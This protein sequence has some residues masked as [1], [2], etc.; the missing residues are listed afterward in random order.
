MCASQIWL[1]KVW[2][3]G[4]LKSIVHYCQKSRLQTLTLWSVA[5]KARLNGLTYFKHLWQAPSRV[6]SRS[7]FHVITSIVFTSLANVCFF[8]PFAR[9]LFAQSVK[10]LLFHHNG[11]HLTW[12]RVITLWNLSCLLRLP[13]ATTIYSIRV[14]LWR[15][16]NDHSKSSNANE[17]SP[18]ALSCGGAIRKA[19]LYR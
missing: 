5:C 18:A 2:K 16:F 17:F 11:R 1:W 9:S 15:S 10:T 12:R 8:V 4:K 13:V 14:Q 3:D 7:T 6:L 19:K